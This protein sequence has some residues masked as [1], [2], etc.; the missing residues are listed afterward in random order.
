MKTD[1]ALERLVL[2]DVLAKHWIVELRCNHDLKT[3]QV[4][5][6]CGSWRGPELLSVGSAV[7]AWADHVADELVREVP[8]APEEPS[9]PSKGSAEY[10]NQAGREACEPAVLKPPSTAI[11]LSPASSGEP[12]TPEER[13]ASHELEAAASARLAGEP[14]E[15]R[16]L[17]T[18]AKECEL[19]QARALP[20][21]LRTIAIRIEERL[22]GAVVPVERP[23]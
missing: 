4:F 3:D 15:V 16:W 9:L 14:V 10:P 12:P 6:S 2:S 23:E 13:V 8:Q 18:L 22:R 19:N 11:S 17:R 20:E 21:Q 1:A 5:C 7:R